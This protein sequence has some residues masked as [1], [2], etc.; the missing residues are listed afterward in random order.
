MPPVFHAQRTA[1]WIRTKWRREPWIMRNDKFMIF[2]NH[3]IKLKNP[4]AKSCRMTEGLKG[5]FREKR[6][7]APMCLYLKS[8]TFTLTHSDVRL[9]VALSGRNTGAL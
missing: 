9:W 7:C 4:Y 8:H 1:L 3:K 6:S 2:R 5:I